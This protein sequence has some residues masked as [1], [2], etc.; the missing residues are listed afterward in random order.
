[1]NSYF[2]FILSAVVIG[3]LLM[4]LSSADTKWETHIDRGMVTKTK[5]KDGQFIEE[6]VFLPG[7]QL[8]LRRY[9]D[10]LH[11]SHIVQYDKLGNEVSHSITP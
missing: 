7:G 6:R 2:R 1:M 9:S 3:F 8:V 4:F 10:S 5:I 11:R